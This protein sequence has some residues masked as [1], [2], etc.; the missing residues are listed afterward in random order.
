MVTHYY[1][2]I[3]INWTDDEWDNLQMVKEQR[4]LEGQKDPKDAS[5]SIALSKDL[6]QRVI[7]YA[8]E[9]GFNPSELIRET[10]FVL[11]K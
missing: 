3:E 2:E 9:K 11:T 8:Q 1:G 5:I 4:E 7:R 10:L 6:K